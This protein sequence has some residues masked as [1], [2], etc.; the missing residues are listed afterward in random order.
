MAKALERSYWICAFAVNQHA[1]I[2]G[3]FGPEPAEG[4]SQYIDWE[5]KTRDTVT[6]KKHPLCDCNE[7]KHFN[8][9]VI[10]CELNKF[11]DLMRFLSEHIEGFAQVVAIDMRF[12]IFNRAWC[13]AELIEADA[14]SM[15]QYVKVPSFKTVDKHYELLT[16]IAV[17]NC[18]ASR[19][20]DKSAILASISDVDAFNKRLQWLIYGTESLF[21]TWMD[22]RDRANAVGRIAARALM[23]AQKHEHDDIESASW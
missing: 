15:P 5:V 21:R 22:G 23:R 1:N 16:T 10:E 8:D 18:Q 7:Q 11:P 3:G 17:E 14:L 2:C 9:D 12:G 4:T 13:V 19:Q 6:G 20:E